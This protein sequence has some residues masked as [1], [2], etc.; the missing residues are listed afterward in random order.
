[1][2]TVKIDRNTSRHNKEGIER[3][4]LLGKKNFARME[5]HLARASES[6][7]R[8]SD[9]EKNLNPLL[10]ATSKPTL[11]HSQNLIPIFF[12]QLWRIWHTPRW[13]QT[14]NSMMSFKD[15]F[16]SRSLSCNGSV[17]EMAV[18]SQLNKSAY[19][20]KKTKKILIKR[21]SLKIRRKNSLK[22]EG[23]K[24]SKM[25]SNPKKKLGED[26]HNLWQAIRIVRRVKTRCNYEAVN[27][28]LPTR[29][30]ENASESAE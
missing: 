10:F 20:A 2:C 1:M 14:N 13:S 21:I 4:Q 25:H 17:P 22:P 3:R 23:V 18:E 27:H 30:Q 15:R 11:D 29:I 12:L 16:G 26:F 9:P 28:R 7:Y 8:V 24:Y 5:S 6:I 19:V